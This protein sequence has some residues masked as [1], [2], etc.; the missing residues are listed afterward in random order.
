MPWYL[1]APMQNTFKKVSAPLSEAEQALKSWGIKYEKK[2]DG[3]LFVPE[4]LDIYGKGLTR[5]PDLSSVSVGGTFL[6]SN[7][8]L[9]SLEGAPHT[10]GGDFN[11]INN[12]LTSLK[13]APNTLGISF[14]CY[15]N[16]LTSLEHV[17]QNFKCLHSDFGTFYSW[18]AI[19][20]NLRSPPVAKEP[21]AKA[22]PTINIIFAL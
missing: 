16:Q 1:S 7:N 15:N 3:T 21:P 10:V 20:E 22:A 13:G 19:P 14:Y 11:C 2:L 12:R 9:T 5:L 8:R 17:P 4:H 18:D 6:C